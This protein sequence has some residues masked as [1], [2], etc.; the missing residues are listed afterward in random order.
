MKPYIKS[1]ADSLLTGKE[2]VV[3]DDTLDALLPY[4]ISVY[5]ASRFNPNQ[6]GTKDKFIAYIKPESL[7]RMKRDNVDPFG[8]N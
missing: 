2:E 6:I 5:V 4:N 3:S 7:K 1:I 8:Q